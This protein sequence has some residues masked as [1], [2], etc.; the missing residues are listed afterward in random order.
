MD[1]IE[2]N[3]PSIQQHNAQFAREAQIVREVD[4][5]LRLQRFP[6]ERVWVDLRFDYGISDH[7]TSKAV[8]MQ[9]NGEVHGTIE[10]RFQ[11]LYIWHDFATFFNEVV[12]HEMAHAL[13]EVRLAEKGQKIDKPHDEDWMD[14]VLEINP[15]VEPVA[16][17]KGEFDE[18]IV[19]L[20]KGGMACACECGGIDGFEVFPN[21]PSANVKLRNEDL[22]CSTC[23]S[24]Y[25]KVQQE[26]WPEAIHSALKFYEGVLAIKVY[27]APLSR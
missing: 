11:G 13:M 8:L 27:H 25:A 4:R 15:E 3:A 20:Q 21:T 7:S 23:N 9:I 24:A 10:I 6:F 1:T 22:M 2:I 17:V 5:I 26:Q 16:K 18:R 12:P 19:K 14:L